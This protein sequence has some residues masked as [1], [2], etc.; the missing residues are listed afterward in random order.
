MID[1]RVDRLR[2]THKIVTVDQL[3]ALRERLR[4]KR[5]VL[6]HGAFDLVHMG[7]L[8]HFEDAKALGD[9]LVVT[10]TGDKFTTKKRAVSVSQE[11]RA[12][13]LAALELVD[14]VA[15]V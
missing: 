4:D 3:P 9:V 11:Y 5:I 15:V 10:I 8:T 14:Y 13:Q 6:C 7:H 12:R 2:H 1:A